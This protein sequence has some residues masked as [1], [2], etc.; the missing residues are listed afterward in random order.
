LIL[1]ILVSLCDIY[2]NIANMP[3]NFFSQ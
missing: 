1:V 2:F 3:K